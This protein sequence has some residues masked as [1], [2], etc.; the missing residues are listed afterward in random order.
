MRPLPDSCREVQMLQSGTLRQATHLP[1]R[2]TYSRRT[3]NRSRAK[4]RLAQ[5]W[6]LDYHRQGQ[7]HY[8]RRNK[9]DQERHDEPQSKQSWLIIPECLPEG[10]QPVAKRW[11]DKDNRAPEKRDEHFENGVKMERPPP[12]NF[13]GRGQCVP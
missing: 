6:I 9:Q 5:S 7:T 11:Q 12:P 13:R 8:C 3:E 4:I 1:P 2:P 10:S